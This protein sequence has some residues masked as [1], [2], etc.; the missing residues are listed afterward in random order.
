MES[1]L[2]MLENSQERLKT[3]EEDMQNV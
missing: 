2:D 1:E 3:L